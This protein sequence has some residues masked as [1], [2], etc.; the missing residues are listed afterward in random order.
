MGNFFS[1][2]KRRKSSI[3]PIDY[4]DLKISFKNYEK[5]YPNET[6]EM[7]RRI[8]KNDMELIDF[9]NQSYKRREERRRSDPNNS[10][11]I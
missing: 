9:M 1:Y 3:I 5:M 10:W 2:N 7:R 11:Y 8:W 6:E 4:T